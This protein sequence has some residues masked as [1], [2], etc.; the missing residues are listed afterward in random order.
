LR[1]SAI[2]WKR[3]QLSI[4]ESLEQTR[5]GLHFKAPKTASSRRTVSMTPLLA[6]ILNRH[7]INQSKRRLNLG[8]DY[9]SL[10]LSRR[11]RRW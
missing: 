8:P 2:D 3:K 10:D 9:L 5:G 1:W 11:L 7:R 4:V 6:E